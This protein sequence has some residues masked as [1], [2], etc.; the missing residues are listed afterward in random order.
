MDK[1]NLDLKNSIKHY[2]FSMGAQLVAASGAASF[3]EYQL[4][5]N[6]RL[7]ETGAGFEDYMVPDES[8]LSG[9][10][11][12]TY[13]DT[14]SNPRNTMPAVKSIIIIGIYSY[15]HSAVY[16]NTRSALKG[17]T[18]RIYSYYPVARKVAESVVK[19]IEEEGGR[20]VHGQ[21][22]PLKHLANHL[23]L[24]TYGK[25]GI[26]QTPEFGSHLAFRNIL[27]DIELE[28]DLPER[29]TSPCEDCDKC[30]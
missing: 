6:N 27:T 18:A 1:S 26:L 8:Q 30:L 28:P 29:I 13:F 19:F 9:E 24:A 11:S 15:D 2:A 17:K 21:H 22:I 23:G 14:L 12:K 7:S 25:N 10:A 20:A 3:E 4:E 5:A 16:R